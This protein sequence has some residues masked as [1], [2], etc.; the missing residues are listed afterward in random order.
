MY[1]KYWNLQ[2]KP[3]E[4]TPDPLFLYH[5]GKHD[6]ALMRLLYAVKERKG[7]AILTGEYGTGKTTITRSLLETLR[8]ESGYEVVLIAN[9]SLSVN[10]FLTEILHQLNVEG[11]PKKKIDLL[12]KLEA[13]LQENLRNQR[14][15]VIII[16]EAQN[17]K[18]KET[19]EELRMLLNFQ[20]NDQFLLTLI[21]VGQP[22]VKQTLN[23]IK[24]F[25][26]RLSIRYNLKL[27]D[28]IETKEYIQYRLRVAGREIATFSDRSFQLIHTYSKGAPRDINNICDL[29]LLLGSFKNKAEIDQGVTEEVIQD[30][31]KE[32]E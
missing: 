32:F 13:V 11:V 8:S 27:L 20:L 18:R 19:L 2:R 5:S 24:Q 7:A 16:D 29:S 30:M 25:K 14:H 10:E 12:R 15:T 22:E 23:K 31:I 26:Q 3:F 17:I 21:L 6:E 1:E 4:N 9:P 28:E